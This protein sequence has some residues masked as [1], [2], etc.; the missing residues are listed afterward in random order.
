MVHPIDPFEDEE[1]EEVMAM[2]DGGTSMD[3]Q[4]AKNNLLLYAWIAVWIVLFIIFI[5]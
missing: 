2:M 4:A 3:G 5:V 1:D